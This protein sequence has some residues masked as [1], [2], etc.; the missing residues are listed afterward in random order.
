MSR[1]RN[2]PQG[3]ETIW[4]CIDSHWQC[5]NRPEVSECLSDYLWVHGFDIPPY[6]T[7]CLAEND[8]YT[9]KYR[10]Y[11]GQISLFINPNS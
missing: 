5:I 6:I 11:G 8:Q 4:R 7:Y 9:L 2:E 10:V 1:R 3:V